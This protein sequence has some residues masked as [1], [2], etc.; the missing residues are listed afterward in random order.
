MRNLRV[1]FMGTPDF[2]VESLRKLYNESYNIVGVIT[3]QDKKAGRG[4]KLKQSPVKKFALEKRLT[5]LQPQNLKHPEFIENIKA[6]NANI[7]VVVAFRMLPEIVWRMPQ[8]G[9]LNLHAS[10]L[11]QYRGAAPINWAI[12]NGETETGITTFYIEQKIDTG[13][14]LLQEKIKILPNETAGT[15]HDKLM[16]SGA[17]L[18]H[19]TL[20]NIAHES[21]TPLNQNNLIKEG[22]TLKKAPKIFKP[23]CEINW[24]N[25]L[26]EI[27]NFIRGLSPY[28][29][30]WTKLTNAEKSFTLK[31]FSIKMV[32]TEHAHQIPS[33]I[34]DGKKHLHIAVCG[35]LIDIQE[36]QLEGKK[37]MYVE[38][39]LRGFPVSNYKVK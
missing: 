9:T 3:S 19:K 10:L 13:N 15:L 18:L 17:K 29:T 34:S 37:R 1:L 33:I 30:A 14:I 4:L 26:K 24:N 7:F 38:E 22:N 16:F 2:A 35:G 25:S 11:P 5:V 31:I 23:D 20:Q 32:N 36:L 39:F 8:F 27:Y 6:L 21:I 12:I 28:P